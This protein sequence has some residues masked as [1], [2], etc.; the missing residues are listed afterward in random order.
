MEAMRW[1]VVGEPGDARSII[2]AWGMGET[3]LEFWGVRF[4][5]IYDRHIYVRTN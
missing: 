1:Q 3:V 5:N 4:V 2:P